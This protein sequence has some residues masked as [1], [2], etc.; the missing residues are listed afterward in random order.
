MGKGIFF[1]LPGA[2][3]HINPTLGVVSEL[4]GKGEQIIYYAGPDSADRIRALGAIPRTYEPHFDYQH[5]PLYASD[6]IALALKLLELSEKA[7]AGI[8]DDLL[9]D[10]PDY[11]IY[12]SC[13]MWG[14][15]LAQHLKIPAICSITT[16]VTTPWIVLSDYMIAAFLAKILA[17]NI[18]SVISGRRRII[19]M[20]N[21]LNLQYGG[22]I[23]H[24]F[25][26]GQNEGDLNIVFLPRNYQPFSNRIKPTFHFVGASVPEGRDHNDLNLQKNG[27]PLIYIS[28][29]TVHNMRDTFYRQC[30]QAFADSP[31]QLIMSV[32]QHT[33]IAK[34]SSIPENFIVRN[35]V[36]QLE[37][38]KQADLFISHG[39]MNSINESLYFGVP[40]LMVPQQDEQLFNARRVAK[41]GAG[42]YLDAKEI[43][44]EN[45]RIQAQRVLSDSSFRQHAQDLSRDSRAG[46]GYKAATNHILNF[47]YG[48]RKIHAA[49]KTA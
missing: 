40:L 4:I 5:S 24:I 41:F 34:L 44:P 46:G 36:P 17:G 42:S 43:T 49:R 39:G 18:P 1:N 10:K 31:Y 33:D 27:K 19:N 26:I 29:G 13:C 6:M 28:L 30:L 22:L 21:S 12:D 25:D 9:R 32:G 48:E 38:L 47:V 7:V 14:K 8:K 3:G 15:Y 2:S 11:I 20:L 37:V 35:R 16:F 23:H 45:L